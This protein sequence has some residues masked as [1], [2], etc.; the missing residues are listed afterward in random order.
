MY[1]P[2]NNLDYETVVILHAS[3]EKIPDN[4]HTMD[5]EYERNVRLNHN[6][7]AN[8]DPVLDDLDTGYCPAE[9][10]HWEDKHSCLYQTCSKSYCL[11][12]IYNLSMQLLVT[13]M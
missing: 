3:I 7:S 5:S 11:R 13:V 6:I 1:C 8:G 12:I 2:K 9:S 10:S 4:I